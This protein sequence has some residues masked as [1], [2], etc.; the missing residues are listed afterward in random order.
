MDSRKIIQKYIGAPGWM[1]VVGWILAVVTAACIGVGAISYASGADV[2]PAAFYPSE[3]KTGTMAY[4]DV[5]GVSNWLF[6]SDDI[7]YY[8][9][10]DAA[11]YLYT[12]RLSDAQYDAMAAHQAYWNRETEDAPAP[13]AY[14]LVGYV[15]DIT[16]L[17]RENLANSWEISEEDYDYYFG[18]KFLNATTTTSEQTSSMYFIGALFAGLLALLCLIRCLG[19]GSSVKKSLNQLEER[20][21]LDKAAQ[22]LEFTE[23]HTVIGKN[24]AI[25]TQDFLFG[26]RTGVAVAYDDIHW[27]YQQDRRRGFFITGACLIIGTVFMK[28]Q[29]TIELNG[30]DRNGYLGDAL[31]TIAQRNPRAMTGYTNTNRK[32]YKAILKGE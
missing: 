31:A 24:R 14:H 12:V 23:G 20:N 27:A 21:L 25:L 7:T 26:R 16:S 5:V 9:A 17:M 4:I 1:A 10:E 11:G 29:V 6:K 28:L 32:A 13:E 15:Q 22:Q 19:V 18:T 3:T 2:V 8:T 30:A